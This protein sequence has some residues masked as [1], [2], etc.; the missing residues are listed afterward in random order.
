[1]PVPPPSAF[2][3]VDEA[4]ADWIKRQMT[5]HPLGTYTSP[6]KIKVPVGNNL[7]RTYIH[8]TKPSYAALEPVRAWVKAQQGW[9]WLEIASGH[10]AMVIAPDELTQLLI[11]AA[12]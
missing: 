12:A 1:L 5:P 4:D 10:D 3:V 6:L 11:S 7:P 9:R 8:C 2:G